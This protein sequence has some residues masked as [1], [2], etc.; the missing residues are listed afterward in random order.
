MEILKNFFYFLLV[1]FAA[2]AVGGILMHDG[3]QSVW[4]YRLNKAPWTPPGWVFGAAWFSIMIL[5]SL[6][7]AK[8]YEKVPK[9]NLLGLFTVQILLNV[10]W[11]YVF[12]N[13]HSI[14]GGLITIVLL[15]ILILYFLFNYY[16]VLTLQ[17]LLILPYVIWLFIATSL[18][19]YIYLYN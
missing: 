9:R 5:F 7:L 8:V 6:Y 11:N 14:V 2:L 10:G 12:F 16:K 4:Y 19:L 13:Q 1:N 18:N 3:P 15:T 17:S